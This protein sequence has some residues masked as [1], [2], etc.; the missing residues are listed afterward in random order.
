MKFKEVQHSKDLI[1]KID[2]LEGGDLEKGLETLIKVALTK[3][4]L[5]MQQ[6]PELSGKHLAALKNL[7]DSYT[8]F[9]KDRRDEIEFANKNNSQVTTSDREALLQ[10]LFLQLTE[11][12][13]EEEVVKL[14]QEARE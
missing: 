3:L 8:K 1:E 11:L 4:T 2:F 5:A 7:T 12:K 10:S 9:N 6:D 14:L 13:G